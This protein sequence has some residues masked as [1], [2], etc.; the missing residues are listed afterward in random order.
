MRRPL[1]FHLI[2]QGKFTMRTLL[3]HPSVR[4]LPWVRLALRTHDLDV[5]QRSQTMLVSPRAPEPGAET[6]NAAEADAELARRACGAAAS[7][8]PGALGMG[9]GTG[10]VPEDCGIPVFFYPLPR[11]QRLIHP[12]LPVLDAVRRGCG[13]VVG[14]HFRSGYAD[15]AVSGSWHGAAAKKGLRA[16]AE[17]GAGEAESRENVLRHAWAALHNLTRPCPQRQGRPRAARRSTP[18]DSAAAASSSGVA[19]A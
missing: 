10:M 17:A 2:V 6:Q 3:Q 14:I 12:H 11:L 16:G 13:S 1:F 4:G 8:G 19:L 5:F 9:K 15:M 18:Q 7:A